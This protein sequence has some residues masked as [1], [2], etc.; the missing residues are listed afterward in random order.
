MNVS[1]RPYTETDKKRLIALGIALP[2]GTF[3]RGEARQNGFSS[4]S[5]VALDG[6]IAIVFDRG[7]QVIYQDG[8]A[9]VVELVRAHRR[10]V[11]SLF[12]VDPAELRRRKARAAA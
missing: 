3:T 10:V 11:S 7:G 6:H 2:R 9:Y 8:G 4:A 12:Y 5:V 1:F